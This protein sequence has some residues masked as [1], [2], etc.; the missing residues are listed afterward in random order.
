M[1]VDFEHRELDRQMYL[2]GGKPDAAVLV[3]R[4]D[5]VVDE[6]LELLGLNPIGG[7]RAGR[8]PERRKP[9]TSNFQNHRATSLRF[10]AERG[11][12]SVTTRYSR[13]HVLD[14]TKAGRRNTRPR[15]RA[16]R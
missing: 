2:R 5:H 10:L 12:T 11:K 15:A 13:M 14:D 4:L 7:H 6:P 9:Q 1:V 8:G 16:D 3:H